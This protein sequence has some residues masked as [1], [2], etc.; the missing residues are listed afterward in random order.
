MSETIPFPM[1]PPNSDPERI[2]AQREVRR[3]MERT[4]DELPDAFRVVFVM[5]LVEE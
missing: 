4:I 5:R 2:T 1:T 3:L